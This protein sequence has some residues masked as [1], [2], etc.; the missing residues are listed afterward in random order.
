MG[1]LLEKFVEEEGITQMGS[2]FFKTPRLMESK[3]LSNGGIS[4]GWVGSQNTNGV[5][6]TQRGL[7]SNL[8]GEISV[9]GSRARDTLGWSKGGCASDKG[10]KDC[11][12]HGVTVVPPNCGS[13]YWQEDFG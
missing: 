11:C 2:S 3:V 12:L 1:I 8:L 7:D 9:Q 10:C 5:E 6:A 4:V 13:H